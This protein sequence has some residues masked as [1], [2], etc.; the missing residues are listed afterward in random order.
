MRGIQSP[1]G[2]RAVASWGPTPQIERTECALIKKGRPAVCAG[3]PRVVVR[4]RVE[5]AEPDVDL[6]SSEQ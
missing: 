1:M 5:T 6:A 2:G 4:A 3:A